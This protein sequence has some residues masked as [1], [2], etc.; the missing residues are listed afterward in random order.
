LKDVKKTMRVNLLDSKLRKHLVDV[1]DDSVSIAH[2]R[3]LLE[4]TFPV[5]AG[6]FPQLVYQKQILTDQDSL[7][8]IGYIT[9]RSISI[10][11][12]RTPSTPSMPFVA[13]APPPVPS[14]S[15]HSVKFDITLLDV[16]KANLRDAFLKSQPVLTRAVK[17]IFQ[18]YDR[19]FGTGN[20]LSKF[21]SYLGPSMQAFA[22]D[23]D[24]RVFDMCVTRV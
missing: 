19:K 7:R 15:V 4:Q 9:N 20:W 16:A 1:V 14:S 13:L 10:V 22:V 3:E 18:Q 17:A 8:S 2:V 11:C 23:D 12:I 24:G 6:F 21:A 5:S